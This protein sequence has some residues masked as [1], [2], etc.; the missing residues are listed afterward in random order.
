VIQATVVELAPVVGVAAACRAVGRPRASHYRHHPSSPPPPRPAPPPPRP[1]PRGLEV[2]ERQALLDILHSQRF[3][4]QAPAE[5]YATLLDEGVYLASISTMYRVLRAQGEVAERRRQATH[6]PTVKP[7][8]VADAPNRVWSWD[9]TKLLGPA[10]WT[11]YYLYT[12][13]DIYSRYAVG[14]MVAERESAALAERLLDQTIANQHV[15]NGQLAI[16]ADSEYV[17][18]GA[19]GLPDPHSDGRV[20]M[21]VP[22]R[23]QAS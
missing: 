23:S 7:E 22:G 17:G 16:H 3:V 13:L 18:A 1:Q 20:R 9:L 14:W 4:D 19:P 6:P 10:K 2:D 15:G 5:V 21:L 11:Y 8:L 12:I